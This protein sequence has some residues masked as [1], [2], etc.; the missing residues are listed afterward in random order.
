M[1]PPGD[2]MT[3]FIVVHNARSKH[4]LRLNVAHIESFASLVALD[5]GLGTNIHMTGSGES[6]YSVIESADKIERIMSDHSVA[7]FFYV[8]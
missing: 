5:P 6:I 1:N 7:E 8:I 3:K 4:K 2:T